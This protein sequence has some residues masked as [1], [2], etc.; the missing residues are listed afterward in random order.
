MH[1]LLVTVDCLGEH[2]DLGLPAE[3]PISE[4]LPILVEACGQILAEDAA[5]VE[6]WELALYGGTALPTTSSL[7]SCNVVDGMRLV[8]QHLGTLESVAG[9]PITGRVHVFPYLPGSTDPDGPRV[10]WIREDPTS[11]GGE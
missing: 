1:T 4:F 3:V 8:L 2:V 10:H 11:R 6:E 7:Q 9:P 5:A